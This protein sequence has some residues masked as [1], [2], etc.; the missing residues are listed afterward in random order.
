MSNSQRS[1]SFAAGLMGTLDLFVDPERQ[2]QLMG[3]F[4]AKGVPAKNI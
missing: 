4:Q 3:L 2:K 1:I